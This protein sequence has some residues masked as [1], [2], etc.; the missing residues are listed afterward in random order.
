MRIRHLILLLFSA[1]SVSAGQSYLSP[2]DVVVSR[3]GS[4]LYLACATGDR[5][6]VFDVE[7]E[8]VSSEFKVE[9]V[10]EL[11]LSPDESRIFAVCG[12]FEGHLAEIDT[13]AGL[14]IRRVP[15][16]HTP[17]SPVI[18]A[19][20]KTVF[21]CNRFSSM[22]QPDVFAFDVASGKVRAST[23]AIRE[24][25]TMTLS[26]DGKFLWVVNHLPLME[27]NL[28][29]VFASLNIY[30]TEDL[31]P[32]AKLDMP[33]GSFAIRG[34]VMSHDGKYLFVTH[35]IGRF[36]VP[37]T[38][39]DRGWI[40]T[41]AVSIFDAQD[42]T[43]VNTVLLDD[44]ML[45]A[46]NPWGIAVTEDDA[47]LCVNAS[48]THEVIFVG[49][50]EMFRRIEEAPAPEEIMN[51]LRFLYG[52]KTRVE[53]EG[54]GPRAI[55]V[56]G[57][58][59][60]VPMYFSDNVNVIEMWDD[61]PGAAFGLPL[62][63]TVK[64]DL[65]RA[66]EMAFNDATFC[67]QHWQ[68]CASCHPDV[69]SD[70]TNWDLLNDGIGNPKQSRSLLYTHKTSPV[71]IT[72]IRGSAEIAVAKGFS[73][74]QFHQVTREREAAMNAYLKSLEPVPSPYL[75][76]D[77][78]LTDSAKR[79]KKVFN[80]KA[81]CVTCHM[82]P[83]YGDRSK[84]TLGLGSDADRDREFATPI[85]IEC[86]RTAPY[87]YD[88]RVVSIKDVITTDNKNNSHGNTKDLSDQEVEDLAEYIKSL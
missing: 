1:L 11:A 32:V 18:S 22:D 81:A 6:Q 51:D 72:G 74:I 38:H 31:K 4:S 50:K 80:G 53:L 48:G 84:H 10:R 16:G 69:R 58:F 27:A 5:I 17:A 57:S 15:V 23:K 8:T 9:G 59:I 61:G 62:K 65:V 46:A 67:Y 56:K 76:Q 66:G 88:G 19:D 49:M 25:V 54:E 20:G 87:M 30:S 70:G 71:M 75:T 83:Y 77:G 35:T 41:S 79:G 28:E 2:S 37:T 73:H 3:D 7:T 26:K 42:Q 63:D 47:W 13:K 29:H 45:G 44:T 64:P 86:W 33:P 55:V 78:S 82:P 52:A 43:H 68:S 12:E 85:L 14:V 39:L 24:P 34:S 60:Y 21:F 40:N 36:T